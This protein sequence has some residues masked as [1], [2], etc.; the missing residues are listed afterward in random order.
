[1]KSDFFERKLGL[2][3]DFFFGSGLVLD[4]LFELFHAWQ[5]AEIL[6]AEMNEEFFGGL[7]EDGPAQNI[8]PAGGR[9][10]FLVEQRFDDTAG[11]N[12]ANVLDFR[13]RGRLLVR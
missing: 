5:I 4:E 7:I 10:E 6:Q 2:F 1:M 12:A 11:M 3:D 9:N 13:N 8:L